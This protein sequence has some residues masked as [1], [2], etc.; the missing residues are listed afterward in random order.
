MT[1][2]DP[3]LTTPQRKFWESEL[4]AKRYLLEI[5]ADRIVL[6]PEFKKSTISAKEKELVITMLPAAQLA[7]DICPNKEIGREIAWLDLHVINALPLLNF[8]NAGNHVLNRYTQWE[9]PTET[10]SEDTGWRA[11][12]DKMT[13]IRSG[14][15][16]PKIE[17]E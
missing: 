13:K 8:N 12:I 1:K 5:D 17:Y 9:Q 16:K 2:E 15:Q 14:D 3:L 4:D 10:E 7:M 6:S 11:M